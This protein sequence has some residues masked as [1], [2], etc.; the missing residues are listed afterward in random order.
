MYF[1]PLYFPRL[2]S[3]LEQTSR[4]SVF[5][6]TKQGRC[7]VQRGRAAAPVSQ[8]HG[9]QFAA[10]RTDVPWKISALLKTFNKIKSHRDE[11]AYQEQPTNVHCLDRNTKLSGTQQI[12]IQM[13]ERNKSGN[14]N[15]KWKD[16]DRKTWIMRLTWDYSCFNVNYY[17]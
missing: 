4:C 8:Q 15:N 17:S 2:F 9:R 10:G 6:Q 16:N 14:K 12:F 1:C 3:T 7:R 11:E 5:D 13:T